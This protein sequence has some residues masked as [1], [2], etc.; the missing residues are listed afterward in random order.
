MQGC[1]DN[2]QI[3][4]ILGDIYLDFTGEFDKA[5]EC[6]QYAASKEHKDGYCGLGKM[7]KKG[8]G[9]PQDYTKA[10]E[11]FNL[12]AAHGDYEA[13]YEIGLM[14]LN[15]L[16]TSQDYHQA[17][18]W[19]TEASNHGDA[20][21]YNAL[22]Y[23][24][25]NG[26]GVDKDYEKACDLFKK[27]AEFEN[28][29]AMTELG[30]YY[31][32]ILFDPKKSFEWTKKAADRG[33]P[34]ALWNLGDCYENG[35]GVEVNNKEA[36][37]YHQMAR[38]AGFNNLPTAQ[39]VEITPFDE[40]MADI[41]IQDYKSA[42]S[43]L[44]KLAK[45]GNAE[46]QFQLAKC[47][48]NG[49]GVKKNTSV[50][51]SWLNKSAEGGF[52]P[53]YYALGQRN[54][55]GID[56]TPNQEQAAKWYRKAAEQ[57]HADAQFR[58]GLMY[59]EGRGVTQNGKKAIDFIKSSAENGSQ[60]AKDYI[61]SIKSKPS[62]SIKSKPSASI[63]N[64][65]IEKGIMFSSTRKGLRFHVDFGVSNL[66]GKKFNCSIN[67]LYDRRPKP[68]PIGVYASDPKELN[69]NGALVVGANGTAQFENTI[70]EDWTFEV[71]YYLLCNRDSKGSWPIIA[72]IVIWDISGKKPK[73]LNTLDKHFSIT[74]SK[75]FF[76]DPT[77][78]VV[79]C[80]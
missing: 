19:F 44:K 18:F 47:Y 74:Y 42:V 45:S 9:V 15:G 30:V 55:K 26:T 79:I 40:A 62:A 37:K 75:K 52:V 8:L 5:L 69:V 7:Y 71:P 68:S 46:A 56:I 33:Y 78:E 28:T 34:E 59:D 67:F 13:E 1:K 14:Y 25:M 22:A 3:C 63:N 54:E 2:P 66:K 10:Y 60:E 72:R 73:E 64:V 43:I 76:S 29:E 35:I 6:Y 27:S 51:A 20:A 38:N 31:S 61:E 77:Y 58:L 48:Q 11:Y 36:E 49:T 39:P 24:Y 53:A 80:K 12:A 65:K 70:C 16:G 41:D 23:M 57:G 32:T 50:A 21:A 17:I 4:S